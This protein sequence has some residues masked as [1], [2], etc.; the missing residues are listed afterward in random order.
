MFKGGK[1]AYRCLR[2]GLVFGVRE[3]KGKRKYNQVV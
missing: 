2:S 3:D 1:C